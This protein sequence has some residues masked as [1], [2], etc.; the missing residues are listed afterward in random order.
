MRSRFGVMIGFDLDNDAANAVDQ[1]RRPDQ[2]RRH[3]M[4][5]AAKE[6]TLQR[7]AEFP[8]GRFCR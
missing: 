2:V 4:D 7:P 3:L 5:A 6:R 1:Q 8:D